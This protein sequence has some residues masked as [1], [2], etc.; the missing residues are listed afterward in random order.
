MFPPVNNQAAKYLADILFFLPTPE[1]RAQLEDY[2]VSW[3]SAHGPTDFTKHYTSQ[4]PQ[5]HQRLLFE[6]DP[7]RFFAGLPPFVQG[8]IRAKMD[9]ARS[10]GRLDDVNSIFL[11]LY[12]T[13]GMETA[14]GRSR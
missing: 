2:R 4:L 1:L 5:E 8:F 14:E 9:I 3:E 11:R 13:G 12:L 7:Q 10:E 6:K